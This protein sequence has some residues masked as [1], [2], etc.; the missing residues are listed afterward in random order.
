MWDTG[1]SQWWDMNHEVVE[2][3][4]EVF[5]EF[6]LHGLLWNHCVWSAWGNRT[7]AKWLYR[8][9]TP[10]VIDLGHMSWILLDIMFWEKSA[11]LP[12]DTLDWLQSEVDKLTRDAVVFCHYPTTQ[13]PDNTTY[14]HSNAPERAFLENSEAV[15][16]ILEWN[17][18]VKRYF[19][20]HTHMPFR[21]SIWWVIHRTIPSVSENI[22]GKI[23]GR[24]WIFNSETNSLELVKID[25]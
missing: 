11:R 7:A 23:D 13:D 2:E 16:E 19:N 24:V 9:D 15:R 12:C 17:S 5:S 14:Y 8:S 4:Q 6:E 21:K 1:T 20:G 25:V 3:L 18:H 22:D 10:K